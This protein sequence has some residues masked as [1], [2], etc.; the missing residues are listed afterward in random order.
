LNSLGQQV[1]DWG[2]TQLATTAFPIVRRERLFAAKALALSPSLIGAD[3]LHRAFHFG[4]PY[5]AA[6]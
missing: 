5:E 1:N 6:D 2:L 3:T 4:R